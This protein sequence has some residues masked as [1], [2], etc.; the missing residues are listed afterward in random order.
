VGEQPA[1][2]LG[3]A[4]H[5]TANRAHARQVDIHGTGGTPQRDHV[6]RV[7]ARV[8]VDPKPHQLERRIASRAGTSTGYSNGNA[9]SSSRLGRTRWLPSSSESMSSS[10][11][12]SFKTNIGVGR[13]VGRFSTRPSA[14]AKSA[15]VTG[16]GEVR[17]TGP[18]RRASSIAARIAAT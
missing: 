2:E 15:F 3:P 12:R 7:V 14:D 18:D 5:V 16:F 9:I 1:N 10:P 8:G 13:T 17:L 4:R 6:V 11:Y